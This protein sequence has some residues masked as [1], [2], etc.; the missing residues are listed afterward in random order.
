LKI[1]VLAPDIFEIEDFLTVEEQEL[2][3]NFAKTINEP[4]WFPEPSSNDIYIKEKEGLL[5]LDHADSVKLNYKQGFFHG[6]RYCGQMPLVFEKIDEKIKS[7]FHSYYI[8]DKVN[9]HRH[10][11][12]HSHK[13][14]KD[15]D[16]INQKW[17]MD[18]YIR[19]GIVI[20]FNDDYSG[21]ALEYPE[22]GIIHKPKSR[23]LLMHAGNILHGT[24]EVEDDVVRYFSTTFVKGN[25]EKP[26]ILNKDLF[27]DIEQSD[28]HVYI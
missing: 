4:D 22:L 24:T 8:I 1:N 5:S 3:L 25:L 6:K 10:L 27:G 2:V 14:H 23:S 21:G 16:P 18:Q 19:Y 9:F 11:K 28:G 15:Y 17:L 20:Y 13:P 7:L 12:G 26:V